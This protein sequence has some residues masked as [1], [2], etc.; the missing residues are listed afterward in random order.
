MIK[1][2]CHEG[3]IFD[4]SIAL[5]MF[6]NPAKSALLIIVL[7]KNIHYLANICFFFVEWLLSI[8]ED[9]HIVI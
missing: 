7:L 5:F 4:L 1:K 8:G 6:K 2:G 9:R 3:R